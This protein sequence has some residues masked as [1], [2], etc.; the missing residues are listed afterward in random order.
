MVEMDDAT[1]AWRAARVAQ[2]RRLWAPMVSRRM[3]PTRDIQDLLVAY[4]AQ[5]ELAV[6]LAEGIIQV[7]RDLELP[8]EM[9]WLWNLASA[10]LE[11][12]WP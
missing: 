11:R 9:A 10:T 6:A 2:I 12:R 1:P 5:A 7:G 8:P 3:G 4:D